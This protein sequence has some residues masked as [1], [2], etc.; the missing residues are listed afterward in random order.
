MAR[1][2]R[3]AKEDPRHDAEHDAGAGEEDE[4]A[5]HR[6]RRVLGGGGRLGPRRPEQDEADNLD[7]AEERQR[8]RRREQ[9]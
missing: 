6:Q 5:S 8:R 1:G 4:P 7:E 3:A 2:P 9:A